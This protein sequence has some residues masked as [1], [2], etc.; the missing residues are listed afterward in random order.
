M[1][2]VSHHTRSVDSSAQQRTSCR[3]PGPYLVGSD[4]TTRSYAIDRASGPKVGAVGGAGT[5]HQDRPANMLNATDIL[6]RHWQTAEESTSPP[7]MHP[8]LVIS[9]APA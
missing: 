7:D 3:P 5:L 6:L 8:R 9:T 1:C 2:T 4:L